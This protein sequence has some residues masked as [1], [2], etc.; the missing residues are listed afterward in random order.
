EGVLVR[1]WASRIACDG[2]VGDRVIA[3][4]DYQRY[5]ERRLERR[6]I[7]AGKRPPRIRGFELRYGIIALR[8]LRQVK[9]A[10]LI[11]QDARV[12]NRQSGLAR[13]N[14]LRNS[15][16]RGLL[17]LVCGDCGYLL[18][19]VGADGDRLV[20]D[21]QRVQ[22]DGFRGLFQV[23]VDLLYPGEG[24]SLQVGRQHKG[25]MLRL[26]TLRKPLS[27]GLRHKKQTRQE[28]GRA[29]CRE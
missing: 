27:A 4:V 16:R 9:A 7:E 22:R 25:I 13:G 3:L 17:I 19:A 26:H 24:G 8:R 12:L 5:A 23:E 11:I 21:L 6:L 28:I 14:L 29:S 18:L 20:L 15:E 10:Q 2:H 1:A